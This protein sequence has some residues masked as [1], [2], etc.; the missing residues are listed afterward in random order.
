MNDRLLSEKKIFEWI[1]ALHKFSVI[2]PSD[3]FVKAFKTEVSRGSFDYP[4]PKVPEMKGQISMF[5][6]S[7]AER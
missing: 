5:D 7:V 2:S 3:P 6:G 4:Q 1:E